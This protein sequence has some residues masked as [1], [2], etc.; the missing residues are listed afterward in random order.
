ML[1]EKAGIAGQFYPEQ[2]KGH[3]CKCFTNFFC[4]AACARVQ[5]M[6]VNGDISMCRASSH[7][8]AI[9]VMQHLLLI[10][11]ISLPT[12]TLIKVVLFL[13]IWASPFSSKSLAHPTS[14]LKVFVGFECFSSRF[15]L[16]CFFF[17]FLLV[18]IACFTAATLELSLLRIWCCNLV[19]LNFCCYLW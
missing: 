15:P 4:M 16:L 7:V 2:K 19:F 18:F 5:S 6:V 12:P 3:L 9:V 17:T 8:W 14:V 13:L 11:W 10:L 1:P